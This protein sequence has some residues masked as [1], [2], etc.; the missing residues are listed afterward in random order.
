MWLCDLLKSFFWAAVWV[1]V[2][3][4]AAIIS[5]EASVTYRTQKASF[6]SSISRMSDVYRGSGVFSERCYTEE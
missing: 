5:L 4:V 3:S 2:V 6:C 1:E